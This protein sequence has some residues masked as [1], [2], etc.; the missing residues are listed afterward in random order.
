MRNSLALICLSGM[1]A[2]FANTSA[3]RAQSYPT[4]PIKLIVPFAAGGSADV[5][6][7]I[8]T[9]PLGKIL[10]QP[11]VI[12]NRP[13]AAGN[14]AAEITAKAE[15]D[16]HTLLLVAGSFAVNPSLYSN[17]RYDPR[18][19]FSPIAMLGATQNVLV[20]NPQFAV[21]TVGE[22]IARAKAAPGRIDFASSGVGTSGHLTVELLKTL[23]GIELTHVPYRSIGQETTDLI[24]GVVP[25]AM[26]SIPGAI[27]HIETGKLRA[28][29]VSGLHRSPALPNLPTMAEAGVAGYEA[30]TWYAVFGPAGLPGP[31]ADRLN[32][33]I[34]R[35]IGQ[36]A[37][38]EKLA[39]QGIEPL[40][41]SPPEL[42]AYLASEIDKWAAV[43]RA[44]NIRP[45]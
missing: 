21:G 17:L 30:T 34:T 41:M 20:V 5:L 16:G 13:G 18:K 26:P 35:L 45:E 9:E 24:A 33:E 14:L 7:R 40:R 37:M 29:A 28:L 32:S 36:D 8:V 38:L 1:L 43:V 2:G 22:L 42:G 31:V 23:A 4:Q 11:L 39:K 15:P 3:A 19:D 27:S 6:A 44:A 12:D 10:G 25:L